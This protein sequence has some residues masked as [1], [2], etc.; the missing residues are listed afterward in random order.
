[1]LGGGD[2]VGV[3]GKGLSYEYVNE[4]GSWTVTDC[5]EG[6][7]LRSKGP[8]SEHVSVSIDLPTSLSSP[9]SSKPKP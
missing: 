7:D 4:A 5:G 3:T 2:G 6:V 8:E 1:M 9:S